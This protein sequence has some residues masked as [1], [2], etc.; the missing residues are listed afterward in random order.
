MKIKFGVFLL[1]FCFAQTAFSQRNSQE[2]EDFSMNFV[3]K[4][5]S[6]KSYMIH[7]IKSDEGGKITYSNLSCD[8][9]QSNEVIADAYYLNQLDNYLKEIDILT[10]KPSN[11]N[12]DLNANLYVRCFYSDNETR[13]SNDFTF[14]FNPDNIGEENKI[15]E[16]LVDVLDAN[17]SRSCNRDV[18]AKLKKQVEEEE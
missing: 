13:Q 9:L 16:Y 4:Y 7:L 15:L 17:T 14:T 12:H 6:E 1:V 5:K 2:K 18:L 8:A 10:F 11:N 3:F